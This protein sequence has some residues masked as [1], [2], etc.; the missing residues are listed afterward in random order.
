VAIL[1]GG[2]GGVEAHAGPSRS[3]AVSIIGRQ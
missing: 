2:G 3:I 1:A